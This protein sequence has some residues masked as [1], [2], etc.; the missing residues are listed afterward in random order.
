MAVNENVSRIYGQRN[1][2]IVD[3]DRVVNRWSLDYYLFSAQQA[4]RDGQYD[5]FCQIRDIIQNLLARPIE[6]SDGVRK[7]LRVMQFLSRI[8][9]GDRLDCIFDSQESC[10]PLESALSVLESIGQE[11]E[12]PQQ[13]L[14]RVH[15][16]ICQMIVVLC[17][18]NGEFEK[19]R[20]RL[21]EYFPEGLTGRG[22]VF[23][24]LA[25]QGIS[26]HDAL[27]KVTFQQFRQDMLTFSASLFPSSEPFLF[28]MAR[29]VHALRPVVENDKVAEPEPALES[30]GVSVRPTEPEDSGTIAGPSFLKLRLLKSAFAQLAAEQDLLTTFTELQEALEQ[31]LQ[32]ENSMCAGA[33]SP[34][35]PALR[36][37][38]PGG[39][40]SPREGSQAEMPVQDQQRPYTV[41]RL[42]MEPDSQ[43]SELESSASQEEASGG[44]EKHVARQEEAAASPSPQ[45]SPLAPHH[46]RHRNPGR[47][48][49]SRCFPADEEDSSDM[50]DTPEGL[51][52]N[53]VAQRSPSPGKRSRVLAVVEG[54]KA[55]WSDEESLFGSPMRIGSRDSTSGDGSGGQILKK[56][57]TVEESEWLKKGVAKYGEG[58]WAQI[59]NSFPFVGR[60]SVNIKDRWRTMRKLKMV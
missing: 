31:E 10:T 30:D 14:E 27:E 33:T 53:R 60:T 57:W 8:N 36:A 41:S 6:F 39:A 38:P 48:A 59:R 49:Y 29:K 34:Q 47:A 12:V 44:Q 17:L 46:P 35:P 23:L 54:T 3:L 4:F 42:V 9:D 11:T 19:A 21:H 43:P 20:D 52:E 16:S 22:A 28:K 58:N 15:K 45:G 5:D 40:G 55:E 32:E 7:K 50:S 2:E 13:E 18:K 1:D 24:N 26:S 51:D 25:Q 56:K 37:R